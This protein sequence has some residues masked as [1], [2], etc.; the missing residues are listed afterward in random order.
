MIIC[1]ILDF[2]DDVEDLDG[3]IKGAGA[4]VFGE[5]PRG[6]VSKGSDGGAEELFF[7]F[8]IILG[9]FLISLVG[10]CRCCLEDV[11]LCKSVCVGVLFCEEPC[12]PDDG[13]HQEELARKLSQYY[14]FCI[15]GSSF[16]R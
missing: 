10:E 8:Y 13:S 11:V 4:F 16:Y 2:S 5:E 1:F 12:E 6:V 9:L 3:F 14:P 15:R 7:H